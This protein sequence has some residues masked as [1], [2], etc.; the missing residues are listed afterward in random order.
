MNLNHKHRKMHFFVS[1]VN[2]IILL[3]VVRSGPIREALKCETHSAR[4]FEQNKF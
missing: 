1:E 4:M 2:L 3:P